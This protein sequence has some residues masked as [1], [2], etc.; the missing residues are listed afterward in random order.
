MPHAPHLRKY[1]GRKWRDRTRPR[2]I[3]RAIAEFG[4]DPEYW[5][6]G[7][8]PS[9][10]PCE[11]CHTWV[12][13]SRIEVAHL[14]LAPGVPGHDDDS[15]LAA[16]CSDCHKRWDYASWALESFTT[17]CKRKDAGRPLLEVSA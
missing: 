2:I 10:C 4:V 7:L 16:L 6:I 9:F 14:Y 12:L 8:L 17:R 11:W 13:I 5:L 15:N 3:L 1:F